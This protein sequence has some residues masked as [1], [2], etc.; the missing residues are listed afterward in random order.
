M[1][2]NEGTNILD[3][4]LYPLYQIDILTHMVYDTFHTIC[5]NIVKNKI[6]QP[7]DLEILDQ[8]YITD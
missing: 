5:L 7:M 1:S 3:T 4:Y 2:S 8:S 6:E